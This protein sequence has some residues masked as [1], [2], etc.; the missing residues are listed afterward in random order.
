[1]VDVFGV[2]STPPVKY[3]LS[4]EL[5]IDSN[6]RDLVITIIMNL[7]DRRDVFRTQPNIYDETFL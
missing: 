1:M 7:F 3:S 2:L 6:F 5:I 4:H